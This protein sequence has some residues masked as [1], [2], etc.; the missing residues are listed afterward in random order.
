[1]GYL[2]ELKAVSA[3]SSHELKVVNILSS[4]PWASQ[5]N[6][7]EVRS[8]SPGSTEWANVQQRFLATLQTGTIT[9][10]QRIQNK[11]LWRSYVQAR[12]RLSKKNKD[13]IN[14]RLLFQGTGGVRPEK[15]YNSEK[16]FDFPST[17]IRGQW[18]EGAHFAVNASYA[19]RYAYTFGQTRQVFL[20]LVVL[21]E[22]YKCHRPDESLKQPPK[23]HGSGMCTR[24]RYD[25]VSGTIDG[26]EIIYVT[27][28]H[29]KAYPAYI[30]RYT[31]SPP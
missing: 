18:G 1:M 2:V 30:I 9:S 23:K 31:W 21:G 14:E 28:D 17:N 13:V 16:G 4:I 22:S 25:S 3:T 6:K 27:Y 20:A 26:S 19:N 15:V 10:I 5:R 11:Q 29:T 12:R 24:E 8:V 7:V